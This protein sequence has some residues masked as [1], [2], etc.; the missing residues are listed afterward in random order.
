MA[1]PEGGPGPPGG[2][3]G[4]EGGSGGGGHVLDYMQ[5]QFADPNSDYVKLYAAIAAMFGDQIASWLKTNLGNATGIFAALDAGWTVDQVMTVLQT[6]DLKR[7]YSEVTSGAKTGQ[8]SAAGRTAYSMA[9]QV[10]I[11]YFK[12]SYQDAVTRLGEQGFNIA[13]S[14]PQAASPY[15]AIIDSLGPGGGGGTPGGLPGGASDTGG[16][17]GGNPQHPVNWPTGVGPGQPPGISQG[18]YGNNLI[19]DVG[20]GDNSFNDLINQA[21][22]E[23]WTPEQFQAAIYASAQF[24]RM[25]PG[26]VRP[27]GSLRMDATQYRQLAESYAA[28][29]RAYGV[30]VNYYRVGLLINGAVSPTEFQTRIQALANI[31]DNPGLQS[32]FNEELKTMGLSPLDDQGF[33]RLMA[34]AAPKDY[35]DAYEAAQLRQASGL[36]FTPLE[37]ATAA[38]GVG[39]AGVPADIQSLVAQARQLHSDIGPE[40]QQAGIT[41]AYL[42]QLESGVDPL[43]KAPQ[44]QTIV[45]NRRGQGAFV[46]G[47]YAQQGT[48][49]GPAIYPSEQSAA[50]G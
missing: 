45:A 19:N 29:G 43:G 11:N 16:Q 28:T 34:G 15:Q 35:Y 5:S 18:A 2:A 7:I 27:D 39:Q 10:N 14:N 24:A 50:Y 17:G 48:G 44:L 13:A 21:I 31:R 36:T 33:F 6:L 3:P 40:L 32:S 46:P 42:V 26:I 47:S 8:G 12:G 9:V 37:A 22:I 25:F 38:R 41:D 1:Y 49:G 4:G 23:Q 20:V 30:D